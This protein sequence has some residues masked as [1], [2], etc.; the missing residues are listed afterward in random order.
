MVK[1]FS[2][3]VIIVLNSSICFSQMKNNLKRVGWESGV[4]IIKEDDLNV[5]TTAEQ[6]FKIGLNSG[7]HFQNLDD[8]DDFTGNIL[9]D[10]YLGFILSDEVSLLMGFSYWKAETQQTSITQYPVPTETINSRAFKLGLEFS[11]IKIY[12]SSL[13]LEPSVSIGSITGAYNA[14][15]S[16]GANLKLSIPLYQERLNVFTSA[17]YQ[18]GSEILN[19]GG[20]GVHY[21]FFGITIG[22]EIFI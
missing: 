22:F 11:L 16:F 5:K 6:K 3:I 1:S 14:N 13:L 10:V 20:G 21:S 9:F 4:S 18:N 17:N 2:I 15:F 7:Y 12:S 19:V 8:Y